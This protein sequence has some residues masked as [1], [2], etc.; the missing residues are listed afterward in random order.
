MFILVSVSYAR[1]NAGSEVDQNWRTSF[2][3]ILVQVAEYQTY[4][5]PN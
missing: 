1:K 3:C 4:T 5:G 2:E